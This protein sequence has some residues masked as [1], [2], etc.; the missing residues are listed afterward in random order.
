MS[1]HNMHLIEL[2]KDITVAKLSN[3]STRPNELSDESVAEFMQV[4]YN[5]LIELDKQAN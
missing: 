2:T 3:P 5:K 4:V 1:A